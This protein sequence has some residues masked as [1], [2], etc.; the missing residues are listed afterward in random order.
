LRPVE[1]RISP[2]PNKPTGWLEKLGFGILGLGILVTALSLARSVLSKSSRVFLALS[3]LL[4]LNGLGFV[5]ISIFDTDDGAAGTLRGIIHVAAAATSGSVPSLFALI[6]TIGFI[7]NAR[8]RPY[9]LY[10]LFV[11]LYA[12]IGGLVYLLLPDGSWFGLGFYERILM[13]LTLVWLGLAGTG[14]L[15]AANKE[16]EIAASAC[17][18]PRNDKRKKSLFTPLF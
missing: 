1:N 14:L 13:L 3:L 7:K 4:G 18:H 15:R 11:G 17:G 9:V 2:P 12:A 8:L 16:N 5:V 10:T 6:V